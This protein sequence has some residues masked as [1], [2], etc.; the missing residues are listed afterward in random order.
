MS[1][2]KL[3][4]WWSVQAGAG[5]EFASG[6]M[7]VGNLD[8]SGSG[9]KVAVG[10]L[11]GL[12]RIYAPTRPEFRVD[13]LLIEVDLHAPILQ[14]LAGTFLPLSLNVSL[15]VLH[16]RSL[17]VYELQVA[18][19]DKGG[20]HTLEKAYEHEL[21]VDGKHFSAFN[22]ASGAFG[23]VQVRVSLCLCVCVSLSLSLCM[24]LYNS[25]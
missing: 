14:L 23:G 5:E 25:N 15:A 24:S 18:G 3:Q 4:E 21:G 1:C 12:L 9:N 22:M 16:P 10:S 17:V 19:A 8:N 2:F 11:E 13:D 6:A 20:Y 7:V